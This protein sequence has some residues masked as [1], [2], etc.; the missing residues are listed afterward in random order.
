MNKY[1][2]YLEQENFYNIPF[3]DNIEQLSR[4]IVKDIPFHVSVHKIKDIKDFPKQYV[5]S[6][7]HDNDELNLILADDG[8]ELVYNIEIDGEVNEVKS[9]SFIWIPKGKSHSANVVRGSGTF[10]CII[11]QEEYKA[12][13]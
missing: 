6:H 5:E 2:K 7:K 12:Y 13:S 8:K 9:P 4:L 1:I 10:I 3:H 11:L